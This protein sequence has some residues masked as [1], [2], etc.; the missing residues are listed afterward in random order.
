MAGS[1]TAKLDMIPAE[2]LAESKFVQGSSSGEP[3]FRSVTEA[4]TKLRT[5]IFL[6]EIHSSARPQKLLPET[7]LIY[8][9]PSAPGRALC[10]T[11]LVTDSGIPF[12]D[13]IGRVSPAF[14]PP[15]SLPAVA[16]YIRTDLIKNGRSD[17]TMVTGSIS[18][19][20]H[21]GRFSLRST[22]GKPPT[23]S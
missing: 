23:G 6:L 3:H 20:A 12:H 13:P 1:L 11:R 16:G 7:G 9:A 10:F 8:L 15:L 17:F 18:V 19:S 2:R 14:R 5:E 4:D 21:W 22:C